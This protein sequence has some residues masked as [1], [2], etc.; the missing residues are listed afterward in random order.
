MSTVLK[1]FVV[2]IF[3]TLLGFAV[4]NTFFIQDRDIIYR[5]AK[6]VTNVNDL[7]IV[8][9]NKNIINVDDEGISILKL[10]NADIK[11]IDKE[12]SSTA[13]EKNTIDN[14]ETDNAEIGE[15]KGTVENIG[16]SESTAGEVIEVESSPEILKDNTEEGN[17][18]EEEEGERDYSDLESEVL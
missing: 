2:L 8:S 13:A 10:E 16:L 9:I 15:V 6:S 17:L 14:G 12:E 7:G 3:L 4:Y 5:K 1:N 18:E 11:S